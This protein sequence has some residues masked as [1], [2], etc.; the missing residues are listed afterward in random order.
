MF[1]IGMI[2]LIMWYS[3]IGTAVATVIFIIPFFIVYGIVECFLISLKS[4][5]DSYIFVLT[6]LNLYDIM[7]SNLR[8]KLI[9]KIKLTGREDA[10][11]WMWKLV[12]GN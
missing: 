2:L 12:G 8:W 4:D 5:E 1:N 9:M 3:I 10:T 11:V 7:Y 6:Y